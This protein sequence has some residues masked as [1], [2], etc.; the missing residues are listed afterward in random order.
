M[1]DMLTYVR[2]PLVDGTGSLTVATAR[3]AT[4][5]AT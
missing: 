1:D 4:T 5:C 2:Y 3:P